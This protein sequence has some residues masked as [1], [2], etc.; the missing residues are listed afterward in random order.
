MTDGFAIRLSP[1]FCLGESNLFFLTASRGLVS[2]MHIPCSCPP[3]LNI[4]GSFLPPS[5]MGGF[6]SLFWKPEKSGCV[7]VSG[8]KQ[9]RAPATSPW[10][11][12]CLW[13][14]PGAGE[15]PAGGPPRAPPLAPAG[16][17]ELTDSQMD[18]NSREKGMCCE[19]IDTVHRIFF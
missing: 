18:Q 12:R 8:R 9:V 1:L 7:E 3:N 11:T 13:S 6:S 2:S 19:C 15:V 17:A 10:G 16:Q 14:L 5:Q 4:L